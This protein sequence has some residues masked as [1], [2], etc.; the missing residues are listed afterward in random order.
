M[1]FIDPNSYHNTSEN[2]YNPEEIKNIRIFYAEILKRAL[3]D[4]RYY[5]QSDNV[6]RWIRLDA[7]NAAHNAQ[8]WIDGLVDSCAITC[9]FIL[10]TLDID[11]SILHTYLDKH[12]IRFDYNDKSPKERAGRKA[13]EILS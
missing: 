12:E 6:D 2:D 9:Q 5:K 3:E 1:F 7:Y 10:E 8:A 4:L 13:Y 11:K